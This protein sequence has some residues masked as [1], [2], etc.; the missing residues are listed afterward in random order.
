M[1]ASIKVV[2][3]A[4]ITIGLSMGCFHTQVE[5]VAKRVPCQ[6]GLGSCPGGDCQC[7]GSTRTQ[8]CV[9]RKVW[10]NDS[11]CG[12]TEVCLNAGRVNHR[13]CGLAIR[14]PVACN[15]A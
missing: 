5:D 2:I 6:C 10:C 12:P 3:A 1:K 7:D 11:V 13:P 15:P 14:A 4:L 9:C 8:R